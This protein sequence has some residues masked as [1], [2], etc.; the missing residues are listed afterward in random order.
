MPGWND[1]EETIIAG[2]GQAYRAP[3]GTPLPAT[4]AAAPDTAFEG[5]GYHTDDGVSVNQTPEIVEHGAWQSRYPIRRHR[6][7]EEFLITFSL[8]QWNEINVPFAFG[9]GEI[10]DLGGGDIRYNPPAV[11][12]PLDE[13][14]LIVD[15]IDG[16]RI[17]RWIVPRGSVTEGVESQFSS[18]EMAGLQ[19]TFKALEPEDGSPAWYWVSNDDA[20]FAAGS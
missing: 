3:V 4:A 1:A 13:R 17:L 7:S 18:T 19:V 5:L 9:G 16:D 8:L 10:V 6:Q 11:T 14:A 15:V 12:D 20:A 2:T